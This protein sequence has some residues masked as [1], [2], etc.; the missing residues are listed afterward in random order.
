MNSDPHGAPSDRDA[1]AGAAGP[2]SSRDGE[3][4]AADG[5]EVAPRRAVFLDRDG[6]LIEERNYPSTADDIVLLP[7][8]GLA[9][10]RLS[11]AG[12][13]RVLLTNQSA[14]SRGYLS[15]EELGMLHEHLLRELHSQGGDL[16][17]IYYCPHHP[18]GDA[19][20]YNHACACRKPARGLLDLAVQE[21][22]LDVSSSIF[23]GDSPRDLF[24]DAG[25]AAARI[26]VQTGLSI[27]DTS[28]ADHVATDITDA[29]EWILERFP[30]PVDPDRVGVEPLGIPASDETAESTA[31]PEP[32]SDADPPPGEPPSADQE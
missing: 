19:V 12:F 30:K 24:L 26:L 31:E 7:G 3:L 8:A 16:E 9:L 27:D 10:Q 17:A 20:G 28:G 22:N 11:T 18:D 29:I 15:E 4:E 21:R 2:G 32:A 23:I 5:L 14:V 25:P 13:Q 6:T 1:A